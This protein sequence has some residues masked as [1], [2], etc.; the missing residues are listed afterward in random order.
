MART[1]ALI[2]F[3][4]VVFAVGLYL[5]TRP[6]VIRGGVLSDDMMAELRAKG[7]DGV[8]DIR[9]DDEIPFGAEGA[10]FV[11]TFRGTD[12]SSESWEYAMTRDGSLT[13][14]RLGAT[15]RPYP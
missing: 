10:V 1:A 5:A 11:C 13:N 12:G 6:T 8:S 7:I 15:P 9:C 2:G 3:I 14:H 4:A